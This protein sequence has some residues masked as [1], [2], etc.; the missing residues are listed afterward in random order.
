MGS[1]ASD[2]VWRALYESWLAKHGKSYNGIAENSEKELRFEIFKNN[3]K[4]VEEHNSVARPYKVGL[5][6][7][8]DLTNEEYRSM[9]VGGRL[10]RKGRLMNR[11]ASDRYAVKAGE[12][13]PETVDWRESGAV[14]PVK[15]QGQCGMPSL[16]TIKLFSILQ[17]V[18]KFGFYYA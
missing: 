5:N 11:R 18:S 17:Y 9:F 15:D 16:P 4:F 3:F 8:A 12:E 6:R 7:F 13:L 1:A 14:A 10:D 2:E